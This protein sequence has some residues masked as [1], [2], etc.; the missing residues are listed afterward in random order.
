MAERLG[1]EGKDFTDDVD[2]ARMV[3]DEQV[4]VRAMLGLDTKD[5]NIKVSVLL[6]HNQTQ[7]ASMGVMGEQDLQQVSEGMA[8]NEQTQIHMWEEMSRLSRAAQSNLE[9][10]KE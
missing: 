9:M 1:L 5:E 8:H 4:S 2:E 7:S 3:I 10:T 6:L